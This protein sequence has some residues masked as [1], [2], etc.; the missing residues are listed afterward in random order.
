MA[1]LV[2]DCPRC[3]AKTMTFDVA[4]QT[5][6]GN[7]YGW[8]N[9]FEIFSICRACRR[10]TI[11]LVNE[12]EYRNPNPFVEPDALV[13]YP[14]ALN[15]H[16]K[17]DRFISLRDN[18][19]AKCPEY[20]SED[21]TAAFNEGAACLA[22][23]CCNAAAT[24]FRLCVDLVTRPLLPDPPLL[25]DP[26][27]DSRPQP[28]KKTRRDLG[29][30]LPWLFENRIL[31]SDL[32]ELAQCVK[33]DGNDGAHSGSLTKPDAEDLLDFTT[34]LLERLITEPERL[35]LAQARRDGRRKR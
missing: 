28:N 16:F 31:P 26:I 34:V 5:F 33:E 22:I 14:E 23:G 11:F 29:L 21:I 25:S 27:D 10:P 3:G 15:Q 4:A 30:R 24:M 7:Q 8:Q 2:T 13:K 20:L 9:W 1:Y 6:A 35:R 32:R 19:V 17:V 12:K 18:I